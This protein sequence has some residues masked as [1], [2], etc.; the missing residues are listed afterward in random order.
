MAEQGLTQWVKMLQYIP[1]NMHTV[2]ALLCF[3][4]VIHWLIF[5]YPPGLFHW[6]CGNLTNA[7]VPA[8]EPWWIWINTS[9]EFIMNDCITTTKQSTTKPCAYFLGYNVRVLNIPRFADT[10]FSHRW[11]CGVFFHSVVIFGVCLVEGYMWNG[12]AQAAYNWFDYICR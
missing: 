4:V 12:Q 11:K 10:L 6:Y 3:F 9:C 5:P 7:L 1:R 2:F 8:K